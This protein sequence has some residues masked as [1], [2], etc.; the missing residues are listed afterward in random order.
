MNCDPPSPVIYGQ[1]MFKTIVY[2]TGFSKS[3]LHYVNQAKKQNNDSIFKS[4]VAVPRVKNE[5]F[6]KKGRYSE[7]I[8]AEAS[9]CLTAVLEYLTAELARKTPRDNK[10]TRNVPQHI[11][12]AVHNDEELNRLLEAVSIASGSVLSYIPAQLLSKTKVKEL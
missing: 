8:E 3:L 9:V 5:S 10:K 4:R 1:D 12:L 2:V 7:R 11:Q 6:L